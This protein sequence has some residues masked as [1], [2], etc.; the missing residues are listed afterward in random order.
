VLPVCPAITG[1]NTARITSLPSVSSNSPTTAAATKAV[2]RLIC[3][4]GWRSSRLRLSG[5]AEAFLLV[6]ADH[7]AG[8]AGN[9]DRAVGEQRL[10]ADQAGQHTLAS[11]H[12]IDR[13]VPPERFLERVLERPCPA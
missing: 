6:D 2:S 13:V 10:A 1:R 12:R 7:A 11:D 9:R 4:H 8:L 3:S 5:V